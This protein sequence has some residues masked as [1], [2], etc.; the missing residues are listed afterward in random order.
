MEMLNRAIED[1]DATSKFLE[2]LKRQD[3]TASQQEVSASREHGYETRTQ[4]RAR[5][6]REAKYALRQA[7]QVAR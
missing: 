6:R 2:K 3:V 7:K 5:E 4:R 1:A